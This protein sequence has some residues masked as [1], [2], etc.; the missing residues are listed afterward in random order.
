MLP[1]T[2]NQCAEQVPVVAEPG[3]PHGDQWPTR[4]RRNGFCGVE[5]QPWPS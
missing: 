5:F 4:F 2:V 3:L 1:L